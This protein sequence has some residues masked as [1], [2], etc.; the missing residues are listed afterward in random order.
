MRHW[1]A[2]ETTLL[3]RLGPTEVAQRT[4]RTV[5]AATG[6]KN[7][8]KAEGV[9]FSDLRYTSQRLKLGR[10]VWTPKA[11]ALLGTM[12]DAE[13]ARQLGVSQQT[14]RRRRIRL[15]L[16]IFVRPKLPQRPKRPPRHR[17]TKRLETLVMTMPIAEATGR[18]RAAVIYRRWQLRANGVKVP[19][20]YVRRIRP[21]RRRT[22]AETSPHYRRS[23]DDSPC[24]K[25]TSSCGRPVP[26]KLQRNILVGS[27]GLRAR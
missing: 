23:P 3:R 22:N 5:M 18:T 1:T 12:P 17:W 20:Q 9:E 24:R 11:D 26:Q 16:P 15:G 14:A 21:H 7:A 27:N 19:R 10:S 6:M 13:V 8:L 25:G 2:A 4:G